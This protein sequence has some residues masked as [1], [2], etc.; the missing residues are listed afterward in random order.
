MQEGGSLN[1]GVT[2]QGARIWW[3]YIQGLKCWRLP[4]FY[5]PAP[6][7][8]RA[9]KPRLCHSALIQLTLCRAPQ[10]SPRTQPACPDWHLQRPQ[11]R[12]TR[13]EACRLNLAP[14]GRHHK[15]TGPQGSHCASWPVGEGSK[16]PI[17]KPTEMQP[18][19]S[20]R[21]RAAHKGKA[22]RT[23]GSSRQGVSHFLHMVLLSRMGD[24]PDVPNMQKKKE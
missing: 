13:Q 17:S 15:P 3:K 23:P 19:P 11:P 24:G 21:A 2:G 5:S 7:Q 10:H 9:D 20:G 16:P 6:Q 14:G 12:L 4:F 8:I 1:S 18:D 22:L